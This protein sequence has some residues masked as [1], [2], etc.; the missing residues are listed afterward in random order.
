MWNSPNLWAKLKTFAYNC[1][2][3]L[4]KPCKTCFLQKFKQKPRL[5]SYIIINKLKITLISISGIFGLIY[6]VSVH[7]NTSH[8]THWWRLVYWNEVTNSYVKWEPS[9]DS[10][11]VFQEGRGIAEDFSLSIYLFIG[12]FFF[13]IL[14]M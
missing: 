10:K 3:Q 2:I 4:N 1:W 12:W 9:V 8:C 11:Y 14:S 6:D 5:S 7:W 13:L